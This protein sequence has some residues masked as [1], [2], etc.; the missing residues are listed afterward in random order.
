MTTI[1]GYPVC[2]GEVIRILGLQLDE[3]EPLANYKYLEIYLKQFGLE[4]FTFDKG[5]YMIG[6]ATPTL[7]DVWR[8]F[9]SVDAA[10]DVLHSLKIKFKENMIAANA[11][12]TTVNI[13]H[14]EG[15]D[16][17]VHNPEPYLVVNTFN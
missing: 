8:G 6:I 9:V 7:S 10:I 5:L 15:Y 3:F 4:L 2:F 14:M 12:I 11:D 1:V 13:S 16:V 17:I